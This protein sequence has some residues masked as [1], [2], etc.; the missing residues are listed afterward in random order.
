MSTSNCSKLLPQACRR[1]SSVLC[2]K[3]KL[4]KILSRLRRKLPVACDRQSVL[5]RSWRRRPPRSSPKAFNG[6]VL[7][8]F[9]SKRRPLGQLV[10]A[11]S[12]SLTP[13]REVGPGLL[14]LQLPAFAP[15]GGPDTRGPGMVRAARGGKR[16]DRR[17][18]HTAAPRRAN[19]P[20]RTTK[21]RQT[22]VSRPTMPRKQ[23]KKRR[24][25]VEL[26]RVF[27]VGAV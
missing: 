7:S 22:H 20:G 1:R 27:F 17:L 16:T 9:R 19:E 5:L 12:L 23:Q 18:A 15:P 24:A 4:T 25:R 8:I 14:S 6:V 26:E 3:P 10:T 2:H 21:P 13:A 11:A